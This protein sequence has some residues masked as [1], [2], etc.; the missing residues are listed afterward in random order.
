MQDANPQAVPAVIGRSPSRSA[1][2]DVIDAADS[3]FVNGI[4]LA[5]L[6]GF[7]L[8]AGTFVFG[9]VVFPRSEK[10]ERTDEMEAADLDPA[11]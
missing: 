7:L 11:R 9:W 8:V 1:R 5:E 2:D 3:A 4:R 10:A 6:F